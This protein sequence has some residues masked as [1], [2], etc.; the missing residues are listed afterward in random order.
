MTAGRGRLEPA[1]LTHL[2]HLQQRGHQLDLVF[3]VDHAD[4]PVE[5]GHHFLERSRRRRRRD[6]RGAA[7]LPPESV[8]AVDAGV[9]AL[10]TPD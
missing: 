2:L 10:R 1:L 5:F 6:A 7:R 4:E 3:D 9:A 8:P